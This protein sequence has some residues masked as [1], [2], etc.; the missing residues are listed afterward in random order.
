MKKKLQ[1]KKLTIAKIN[2]LKIIQGGVDPI[3]GPACAP[4]I[5]D[6]PTCPTPPTQDSKIDC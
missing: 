5:T 2:N 3:S 6:T 4:P 1:L